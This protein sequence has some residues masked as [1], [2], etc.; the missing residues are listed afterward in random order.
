M[1]RAVTGAGAAPPRS[2]AG[3]VRYFAGVAITVVAVL[4]QY[5]VPYAWRASRAVYGSFAGDLLVVYGVPIVAFA[6][7]VG[8][9]PLTAWRRRLGRAT[10]EGLAW[11][12]ALFWLGLL[13]VLVLVIVYEIIDPA[14]LQF[15]SRSNPALAQAKSDPWFFVGFSFVVGAV[16]E[17]IFRGWIFGYWNGRGGSWLVPA[18][19]TSAVFAGVHLY[20]GF[21]YG[22]AAPLIYPTLFL[23]GFAFAATYRLSGGNLVVPALLHGQMDATAFLGAIPGWGG[24]AL[25]LRYGL[26]L[27]GAAVAAVGYFAP[28]RLGT[29]PLGDDPFAEPDPPPAP[30]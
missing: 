17:V 10:W 19:W 6:V 23:A 14:A 12:S 4:S 11:Y 29:P 22:P 1:G 5:Y 3:L 25:A 30:S 8:P 15:L 26:V 20:Y 27:V 16:E 7:L 28:E 18:A 9:A 21:T 24:I 13:L 2:D